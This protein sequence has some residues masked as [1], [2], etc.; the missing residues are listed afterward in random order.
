M[1]P[2]SSIYVHRHDLK[3]SAT[4]GAS[5]TSMTSSTAEIASPAGR[6]ER[7]APP[8]TESQLDAIRHIEGN[9]QIIACAGSGKTQV[10]SERVAEILA[11]KRQEGIGP[12]NIVAFTFTDRA[13]AALKDRIAQRIGA[14]LGEIPGLAELYVGTIHGYCL[15]LL[16]RKVPEYFKYQ[17]L[18][19]VQTRLVIDRN[20]NRSGMSSLGL[21]R[22]IDSRRYMDA[23][24]MLRE[25]VVDWQV[26]QGHNVLGALQMYDALLAE[27]RYL[28]YTAIIGKTVQLIEANPELRAEIA[29]SVRFLI[30]DEY[31]DV[32]PL[33]ERLIHAIHDLGAR[34]CVVGDDDQ[35]LYQFRGTDLSNILDFR[36]RYPDVHTVTIAENFRSSE[37]VVDVG[38]QIIVRNLRR[39]PKQM[40]AA[41]T[42]Q[43][44]RGDI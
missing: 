44:V 31:Q 9:L 17:V 5:A 27:K 3:T 18:T 8:Y 35:T 21:R 14:R 43:F 28:D 16:Q 32:N 41:K 22:Y 25:G 34:V 38:R 42:Q 36:N 26:L 10:I 19:E 7:A 13:A 1:P 6:P 29:G 40:E 4:S 2:R 30:V 23:V 15:D 24:N 37:G 12:S 39:L 33:Q 11:R 20:S